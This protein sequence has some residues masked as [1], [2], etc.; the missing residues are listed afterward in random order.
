MGGTGVDEV[1]VANVLVFE[2]GGLLVLIGKGASRDQ[3]MS[4]TEYFQHRGA[5]CYNHVHW[6]CMFLLLLATRIR[7]PFY[8]CA[9][10]C[11]IPSL[12]S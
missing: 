4:S 10:D 2:A 9:A 7:T 6:A 1:R 5:V 8:G 12:E 11:L 3:Q